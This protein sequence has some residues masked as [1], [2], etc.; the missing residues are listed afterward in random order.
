MEV[1]LLLFIIFISIAGTH[2]I[3]CMINDNNYTIEMAIKDNTI[4]N[5]RLSKLESIYNH[6]HEN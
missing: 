4:I 3:L 2:T 6:I 1:Y 5:D